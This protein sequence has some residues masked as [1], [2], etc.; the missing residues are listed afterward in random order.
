MKKINPLKVLRCCLKKVRLLKVQPFI[1]KPSL[2]FPH[3]PNLPPQ[4]A[5]ALSAFSQHTLLNGR[6]LLEGLPSGADGLWHD[7]LKMTTTKQFI[8]MQ[9][10]MFMFE[11]TKRKAGKAQVLR[12]SPDVWDSEA[13]ICCLAADVFGHMQTARNEDNMLIFEPSLLA[14]LLNNFIEGCLSY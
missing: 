2:G 6:W 9:R 14:S 1:S 7:V 11:V 3:F 10:I 12:V 13:D 4:L 8:F 5:I